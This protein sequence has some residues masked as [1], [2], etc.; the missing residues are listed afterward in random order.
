M[1]DSIVCICTNHRA[2]GATG[3]SGPPGE[4]GSVGFPGPSGP[5][6][7]AGQPGPSV[8]VGKKHWQNLLLLKLLLLLL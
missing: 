4:P 6:G 8:S 5:A 3:P 2:S 1:F 7:Q